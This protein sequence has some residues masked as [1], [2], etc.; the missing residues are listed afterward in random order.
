MIMKKIY[1]FALTVSL[2]MLISCTSQAQDQWRSPVIHGYGLE[3][4]LPHAAVQPDTTIQY[5]II[6]E[7]TKAPR[8]KGDVTPGLEHLARLI[9]VYDDAGIPPSKLKLVAVV[10]G[11]ATRLV[12][13]NE[14]YQK[15]FKQKNPDA[16]LVK[17][18]KEKGGVTF[19]V[20]GQALHGMGYNEKDVLPQ[21]QVALSALTVVPTY[22]LRGYALM[23][24]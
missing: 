17:L 18:L 16:Q 9:N 24:F 20:C 6:F 19:Y 1:T 8:Q 12:L 15:K 5:K 10:T 4:P 2:F 14:L 3:M 23:S 7:I 11:P 13:N 21:F 22:E